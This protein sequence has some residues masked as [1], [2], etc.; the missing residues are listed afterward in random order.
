MTF[1]KAVAKIVVTTKQGRVTQ[2]GLSGGV[3]EIWAQIEAT[4]TRGD[5]NAFLPFGSTSTGGSL[6]RVGSIASIEVVRIEEAP[7]AASPEGCQPSR[8]DLEAVLLAAA[9]TRPLLLPSGEQL[10]CDEK[11]NIVFIDEDG[12]VVE[13]SV[14]DVISEAAL[15][16]CGEKAEG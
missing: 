6:V 10:T 11:G 13:G 2:I 9:A 4:I 5:V 15:A 14:A 1:T 16:V 7:D 8:E 3:D 12:E